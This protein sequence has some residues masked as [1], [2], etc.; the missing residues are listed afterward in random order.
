LTMGQV[1]CFLM[2]G[3]GIVVFFYSRSHNESLNPVSQ[4]QSESPQNMKPKKKKAKP[5]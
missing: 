3:L 4:K 1:L 2:M 5:R